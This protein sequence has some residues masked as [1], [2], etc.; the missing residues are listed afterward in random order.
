[1]P[2]SVGHLTR[3]FFDVLTSTPLLVSERAAVESW[4]KP[5][6][7]EVFFDQMDAD[8]RHGYHAALSV[9]SDGHNDG[10]V[11][12]A[13]LMHDVG[14]RHAR[15]GVMGRSVASVMILLRLPLTE[16]VIRYRDHGRNG[17]REL[18]EL[19]APSLAIEFALHHQG[20]RPQTIESRLWQVLIAADQA[21][22]ARTKAD[23]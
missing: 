17:A 15:L 9:I 7:V 8:Q 13:A 12:T 4:L 14:K 21:P 11:I 5:E 1:M 20:E 16:R 22:K 2:G 19:G 6:M 10:E 3:R 23:V 18:T